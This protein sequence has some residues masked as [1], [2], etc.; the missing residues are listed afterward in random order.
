MTGEPFVVVSPDGVHPGGLVAVCS[1]GWRA[2]QLPDDGTTVELHAA[3]CTL[4]REWAD[5]RIDDLPYTLGVHV[6]AQV[7]D[8]LHQLVDLPAALLTINR[9]LAD[10][11][12]RDEFDG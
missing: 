12:D 8:L 1:C 6:P 4:F 9:W 7:L 10:L 11:D 2:E 5:E 3:H